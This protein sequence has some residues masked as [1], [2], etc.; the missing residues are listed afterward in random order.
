MLAILNEP[1]R[2]ASASKATHLE[3]ACN[4]TDERARWLSIVPVNCLASDGGKLK[5]RFAAKNR[6]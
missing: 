6:P 4:A 5:R 1:F 2:I 3:L